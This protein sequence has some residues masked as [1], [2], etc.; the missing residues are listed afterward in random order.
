MG[1]RLR[2]SFKIAPGI[3]LNLSRRGLGVSAGVRGFRVSAGPSGVRRTISIPGTGL[4]NTQSIGPGRTITPAGRRSAGCI[5][6]LLLAVL[7]AV[8]LVVIA[9]AATTTT[10]RASGVVAVAQEMFHAPVRR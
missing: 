2:K 1:W 7:L 5:A 10:P 8:I 4:Y 3:R 6:V 9:L